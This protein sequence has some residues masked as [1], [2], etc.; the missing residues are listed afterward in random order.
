M[1]I[2]RDQI[3]A[4]ADELDRAGHKPTLNAVRKAIGG[5]SFTTIQEGLAEWKAK[6]AAQASPTRE[7][8]PAVLGERVS[9]V[10]TDIWAMAMDLASARLGADREALE[11]ERVDLDAARLEAAEAADELTKELDGAR[12]RISELE[13]AL[14]EA[15]AESAG[16]LK[17]LAVSDARFTDVTV[18]LAAERSAANE[19][20]A[21]AV[22][23]REALAA[24]EG[25]AAV[26]KE[27]LRDALAKLE[28]KKTR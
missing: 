28:P 24:S 21:T 15:Q 27:Q 12:V 9:E 20:R 22:A 8:P 4:A 26:L 11:R 5:G 17:E 2:S 10:A 13:R 19:A 14:A 1:A 25:G 3:W 16:R 7:P 23:A 6:R 18:Q